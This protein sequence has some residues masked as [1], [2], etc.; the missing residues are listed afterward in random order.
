MWVDD[1]TLIS[2]GID[3]L[4]RR[5]QV[6]G[7][8]G[9]TLDP[10]LGSV[11]SLAHMEGEVLAA[12]DQTSQLTLWPARFE[13]VRPRR[14]LRAKRMIVGRSP[15]EL[16]VADNAALARWRPDEEEQTLGAPLAAGVR[17]LTCSAEHI[18]VAR[19]VNRS[20]R[21]FT[22]L[23][24]RSRASGEATS[25][26]EMRGQAKAILPRA[27]GRF[28]LLFNRRTDEPSLRLLDPR[29]GN[30]DSRETW[31]VASVSVAVGD[32]DYWVGGGW[33]GE[34][35]RWQLIHESSRIV[36][37]AGHDA[38][39]AALTC[40]PSSWASLDRKG[41]LLVWPITVEPDLVSPTVTHIVDGAT[42]LTSVGDTFV[43]GSEDGH[44]HAWT[45]DG[46][47]QRR[48]RAHG[49]AI[50]GLQPNDRGDRLASWA[51]DGLRLWT[52]DFELVASW[53]F[54]GGLTDLRWLDNRVIAI[55][56]AGF[57]HVLDC[58]D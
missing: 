1:E 9:A 41:H 39:V 25:R 18:V 10:G 57:V 45:S 17:I 13:T 53:S 55:D 15:D 48:V 8:E 19:Y 6:Q 4:I 24:I 56:A 27:D 52:M 31:A 12:I 49:H 51:R 33:N 34:L 22:D 43:V 5:H 46:T 7:G 16:L 42:T 50:T 2:A 44:L 23:E 11:G 58:G 35:E 28:A 54:A 26:I 30:V 14:S 47:P 40:A 32:D 37:F 21:S 36:R 3:G 38:P 20:P 29:T